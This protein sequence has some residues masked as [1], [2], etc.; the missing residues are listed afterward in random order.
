MA[1]PDRCRRLDGAHYATK[2][3]TP[4]CVAH[5]CPG[6]KPCPRRHCPAC[7]PQ[8][9]HLDPLET[10]CP[11]CIGQVRTNLQA[12]ENR[13]T[14]LLDEAIHTGLESEAANLAGPAPHPIRTLWRRVN[15]TNHG[16]SNADPTITV[17]DWDMLHPYTCL[18][19]WEM[20]LREDFAHDEG[21]TSHTLTSARSYLDWVLTDLAKS[22]DHTEVFTDLARD[23]RRL[24]NHLE[25]T[26]H[27][28]RAPE[29]GAPCPR[30]PTTGDQPA[31]P[32]L[33]LRRS[34]WCES[35]DCARQHVATDE[36]DR[37]QCPRNQDHWWTGLDYRRWV[38]DAWL[39]NATRLNA[40]QLAHRL[41]IPA[42]TIRRWASR[43]NDRPPELP[44][45]GRDASGRHVYSV[46]R[47]TRLAN[48]TNT[49][50]KGA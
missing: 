8:A 47:A 5:E 11:R 25:V 36:L 49:P 10:I 35:L 2:A 20:W 21:N 38:A 27:D 1:T 29:R 13:S 19:V 17:E 40:T 9:H 48:R 32:K 16:R 44:T 15:A 37:W 4:D 28:S 14:E 22:A 3:H 42:S 50:L 24:R 45:I 12:I 23:I 34:H 46:A 6:C 30:C 31:A 39:A 26:L 33:I 43:Q 18:A 41:N 7:G